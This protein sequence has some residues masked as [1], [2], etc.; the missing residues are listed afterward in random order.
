MVA[1]ARRRYAKH[2]V[3]ITSCYVFPGLSA[4]AAA[5]ILIPDA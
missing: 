5:K 2:V 4:T 1:V 3:R